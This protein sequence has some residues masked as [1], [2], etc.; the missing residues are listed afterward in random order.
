MSKYLRSKILFSNN[1]SAFKVF[2]RMLEFDPMAS[3]VHGDSKPCAKFNVFVTT[4]MIMITTTSLEKRLKLFWRQ[5]M[6]FS[7]WSSTYVE[8]KTSSS[9]FNGT[10]R[11]EVSSGL[12]VSTQ[13]E[14]VGALLMPQS[15][16][17]NP[18]KILKITVLKFQFSQLT[19]I[20]TPEC[21]ALEF[22]TS[23]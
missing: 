15:V 14:P 10:C 7:S 21:N 1:E 3:N 8:A 13:Y 9:L 16:A 17:P 22:G 2:E 11:A 20:E 23:R 19:L 12:L 6:S 5:Q 18:M 4:V